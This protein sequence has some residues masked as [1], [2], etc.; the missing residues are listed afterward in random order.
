M[1]LDSIPPDGRIRSGPGHLGAGA[2]AQG[3]RQ[4]GADRPSGP[5]SPRPAPPSVDQTEFSPEVRELAAAEEIPSGTIPP[6][7]LKEIL[8][9]LAHGGHDQ[10]EVLDATTEGVLRDLR[11]PP[12]E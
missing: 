4:T 1:T 12:E 8:G 11:S 2:A 7:R 3:A 9:R 10:P 6:E 5:G